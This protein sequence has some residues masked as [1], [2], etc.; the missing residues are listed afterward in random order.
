MIM[1]RWQAK[2]LLHQDMDRRAGLKITPAHNMRHTLQRIIHHN[3][4][5]IA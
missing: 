4:N 5:V 3:S 1:R 2:M